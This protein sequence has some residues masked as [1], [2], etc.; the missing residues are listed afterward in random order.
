M[1]AAGTHDPSSGPRNPSSGPHNP[2][3]EAY[4]KLH[5]RYE[6]RV[7]EPSPPAVDL[8]PWF[9]DDPVARGEVPDG[10]QVVS[11]ILTGD[12]RWS[13]L[14]A[15]D[16]GLAAWCKDR[17]LGPYHRLQPAPPNLTETRTKLH[18]LAETTISP[19]RQQ[20]NGKI[21][22]RY[23][24]GGFGTPFFGAD[25]QL[26][27]EG[28][29]LIR[30]TRTTAERTPLDVD[31][32]ASSFL[33]DWYGFAASVLEELRATDGADHDPSRVQL[34]PEHFDMALE[35]GSEAAGQRAAYG[36]SPGDETHPEPYVYVA[37]WQPP[38]PGA[39]WQAKGF[40]GAEMPYD[41]ILAADDQ[42]GTVLQFLRLRLAALTA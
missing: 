34:W 26:R 13:E 30:S 29:E 24:R 32:G 11:P 7:L 20:A 40:T 8:P 17:W 10:W 37:P 22:L 6:V 9:A 39:L 15:N 14:A 3:W 12:L 38:P 41:Q 42:R 23:T 18:H 19:A 36:L 33:G 1:T 4:A 27:V 5:E 25:E 28:A 2:S 31:A 16:P 21:G 35:L